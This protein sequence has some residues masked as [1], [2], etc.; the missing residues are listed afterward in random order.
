MSDNHFEILA[1]GHRRRIL[2]SLLE[3]NAHSAVPVAT[4]EDSAER[5]RRA[6][7][8]FRHVHLPKLDAADFV[9]WDPESGSVA[10]GTRFEDIEPLLRFLS[11]EYGDCFE[12]SY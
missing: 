6:R 7:I 3:E 11:D 5:R 8:A 2:A 1:N 10:R 4:N 9:D 12:I